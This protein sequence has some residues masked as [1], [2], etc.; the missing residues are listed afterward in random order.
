MTK[1]VNKLRT[2]IQ[3]IESS[4]LAVEITHRMSID[5][6]AL[7]E[8]V[9]NGP[10]EETL[11]RRKYLS[12]LLVLASDAYEKADKASAVFRQ[13]EQDLFK[14]CSSPQTLLEPFISYREIDLTTLKI[15]RS[16]YQRNHGDCSSSCRPCPP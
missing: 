8:L 10:T 1:I 11:E 4:I 6:I 16:Y 12:G 5:A 9:A 14:V 3:A 13:A 7:C 2:Y 15:D